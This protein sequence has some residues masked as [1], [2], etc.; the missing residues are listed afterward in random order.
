MW[1]GQIWAFDVKFCFD[2]DLQGG[3]AAESY[4]KLDA[5]FWSGDEEVDSVSWA[6]LESVL[7]IQ[8]RD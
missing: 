6:L 4:E 5:T 7:G 2:V 8:R 3:P 1:Q